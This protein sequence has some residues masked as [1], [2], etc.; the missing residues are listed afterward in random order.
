MSKFDE[1][2]SFYKENMISMGLPYEDELFNKITKY[3]GLST[4]KRDAASVPTS[5]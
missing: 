1:K 4:F 3:L 2:I 5:N